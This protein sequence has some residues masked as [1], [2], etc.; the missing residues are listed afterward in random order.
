MTITQEVQVWQDVDIDL[1]I[2]DIYQNLSTYEKE[3]LLE[4]LREDRARYNKGYYIED[5]VIGKSDSE[6][7]TDKKIWDKII[8]LL[9]YENSE[10]L[11][12]IIEELTYEA[13]KN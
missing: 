10:L 8:R 7:L 1:D 3:E 13:P 12:Y 4:L 11:H 5:L 6:F 9:K 2:D